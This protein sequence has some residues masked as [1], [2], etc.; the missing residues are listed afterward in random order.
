MK[1][2]SDTK[3]RHKKY[4]YHYGGVKP[5]L[6]ARKYHTGALRLVV[7]R[8][9]FYENIDYL[10]GDKEKK[11]GH[12]QLKNVMSKERSGVRVKTESD[13][14]DRHKKYSYHYGGV[15]PT[16]FARKY[17]TG[18]LRLVV[19]RSVFYENID[20]LKG[21]KEKKGGHYQLKNVMSNNLLS[22][23]AELY[24]STAMSSE[25]RLLQDQ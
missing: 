13:T 7:E 4:S 5:T 8:S 11:G 15:K 22:S 9:V 24:Q 14:K 12:Y 18:A 23:P 25:C 17:H 10:K 16:L 6:F 21:D 2:E 3:D 1:T 19:E 20:Y